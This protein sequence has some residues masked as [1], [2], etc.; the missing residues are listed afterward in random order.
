[1]ALEGSPDTSSLIEGAFRY[2]GYVTAAANVAA[3]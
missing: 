2:D 3:V 1:M